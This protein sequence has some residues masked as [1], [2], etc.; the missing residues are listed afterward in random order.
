MLPPDTGAGVPVAGTGELFRDG[1]GP[2]R[3]C[4]AVAATT[5][6]PP[7]STMW[8]QGASV[9][10]T[11]ATPSLLRFTSR[12]GQAATLPYVRVHGRFHNGTLAV[13]SVTELPNGTRPPW[14]LIPQGLPD[15]PPCP[16][17]AGGWGRYV[18]SPAL[19]G[20]VKANANRF[21]MLQILSDVY[22]VGTTGD[23]A[24]ARSE[25]TAIYSGNLCVYHARFSADDLQQTAWN[26]NALTSVH[27]Y[28]DAVPELDKV[29]VTVAVF[30]ADTVR[31]LGDTA[32]PEALLLDPP[33]LSAR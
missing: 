3:F 21:T 9:P 13:D 1:N 18:Q 29:R 17:P 4:S 28:A 32:D 30:D 24:A 14:S 23:V 15:T 16:A 10:T 26:L 12:K 6:G 31:A 20:H 33:L 11:G 22:V 8:C 7:P 5:D 27:L 2:I 19:E 25:L